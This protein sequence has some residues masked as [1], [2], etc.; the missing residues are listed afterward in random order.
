[1]DATRREVLIL[2]V[3]DVAAAACGGSGSGAGG[4][5]LANGTNSQVELN[6]GHALA[7]PVTESTRA[8]SRPTTSAARRTNRTA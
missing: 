4:N 6:H 7:V 2:I 5:C 1:M 8:S 3:G